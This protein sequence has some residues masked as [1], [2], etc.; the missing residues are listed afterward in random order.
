MLDFGIR[1]TYPSL[2]KQAVGIPMFFTW[3]TPWDIGK[4][5]VSFKA[6]PFI[7]V[8]EKAPGLDKSRPYNPYASV[9]LSWFLGTGWNLSVGEGVQVGFSND[10]TKAIGRDFTA[11]QQNV[12]LTYLRN[13]WNVTTN[14]FYTTGRTRASGSQPHTMNI[15]FTA[16]KHVYRTDQGPIAYGVWD[17]NSPSVGYLPNGAK[18]SELAV[19]WLWGYLIGNLVQIQGRLTTDVYQ[20][21]YGGRDTRMTF[22]VV[23]P[24]WTPAA[25]RPRN[26]Q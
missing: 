7:G 5:H 2:T 14:A 21:N 16:V 23:F 20:N 10:L 11:F 19:G 9:W 18:Q 15:D 3:S 25:P 26:A 22:M 4:T 6:A 13:N 17:L 24:M 1:N 12:A 8:I